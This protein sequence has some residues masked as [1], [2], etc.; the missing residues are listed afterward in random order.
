LEKIGDDSK[1]SSA[2]YLQIDLSII[3]TTDPPAPAIMLQS[4]DDDIIEE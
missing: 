1:T 2:G 3:S 4:F